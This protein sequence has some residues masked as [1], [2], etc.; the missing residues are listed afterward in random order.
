MTPAQTEAAAEFV[1]PGKYRYSA[2]SCCYCVAQ[3]MLS[4]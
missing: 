1:V 2:Y 4:A 3:L